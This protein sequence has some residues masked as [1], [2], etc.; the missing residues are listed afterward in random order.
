MSLEDSDR[1]YRPIGVGSANRSF[2]AHDLQHIVK[3]NHGNNIARLMKIC[4]PV[5]LHNCFSDKQQVLLFTLMDMTKVNAKLREKVLPELIK[6]LEQFNPDDITWV[7]CC[8]SGFAYNFTRKLLEISPKEEK[9]GIA[10]FII[11]Q[12]KDVADQ[13]QPL[14]TATAEELPKE[15]L[16]RRR[17]HFFLLQELFHIV[18]ACELIDWI[19]HKETISL[20]SKK[21]TR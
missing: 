4:L 11:H 14:N 8:E 20:C 10:A 9:V 17:S 5:Q 16:L 12:L 13:I 6:F 1:V 2:T 18:A 19:L 15:E 21:I 3:E 7:S